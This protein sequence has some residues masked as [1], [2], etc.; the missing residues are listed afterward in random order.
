VQCDNG[1][2]RRWWC[3]AR[4]AAVRVL[5]AAIQC[6]GALVQWGLRLGLLVSDF[7]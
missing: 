4:I 5:T 6:G 1:D 2:Q 7:G 3:G